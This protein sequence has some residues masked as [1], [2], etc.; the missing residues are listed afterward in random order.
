MEHVTLFGTSFRSGEAQVLLHVDA[1][2]RQHFG[3]LRLIVRKKNTDKYLFIV[4]DRKFE[5]IAHL[6]IYQLLDGQ[7]EMTVINFRDLTS[8]EPLNLYTSKDC[9]GEDICFVSLKE[10]LMFECWRCNYLTDGENER[11]GCGGAYFRP[12]EESRRANCVLI[13]EQHIGT[14]VQHDVISQ[15]HVGHKQCWRSEWIG[16]FYYAARG[17]QFICITK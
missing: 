7:Q 11:W 17:K 14:K 2:R 12:E 6:G 5:Y 1:A 8:A 9:H 3:I 10:A 16:G 4:E 15:G 13:K